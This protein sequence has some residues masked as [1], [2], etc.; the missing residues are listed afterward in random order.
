MPP[1]IDR[2]RCT[3]C[4]TCVDLCQMD[5]FFG[6]PRKNV[7]VAA[8]PEECWHCNT[9]VENCPAEAVRLR[10]PLPARLFCSPRESDE[11]GDEHCK[12][13]GGE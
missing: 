4:G 11:N 1:V 12:P 6:S 10:I 13:T 9:C 3:G 8:Y 7:P 5:V 2:E